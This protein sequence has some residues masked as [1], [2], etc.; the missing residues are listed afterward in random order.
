MK[1]RE[2]IKRYQVSSGKDWLVDKE[3]VIVRLFEEY[4]EHL[5]SNR[6]ERQIIKENG[7]GLL[8]CPFCGG[9]P[10]YNKGMWST[11][12]CDKCNVNVSDSSKGCIENWNKRA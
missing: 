9:E 10:K 6:L 5:N 8:P 7:E 12:T 4:Q 3:D 11:V 2:F 1:P